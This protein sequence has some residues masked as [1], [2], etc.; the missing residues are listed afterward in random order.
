M[1]LGATDVDITRGDFLLKGEYFVTFSGAGF[2]Q[3]PK[4][5]LDFS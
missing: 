3:E 5:C 2:L 1:K 4:K